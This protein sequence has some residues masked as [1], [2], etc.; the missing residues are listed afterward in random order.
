MF[1]FSGGWVIFAT[2]CIWVKFTSIHW[3]IFPISASLSLQ[4]HL[5]I[6]SMEITIYH[7]S[8]PSTTVPLEPMNDLCVTMTLNWSKWP[9]LLKIYYTKLRFFKHNLNFRAYVLLSLL[10]FLFISSL[11]IW[12]IM[13]STFTSP[14]K[15]EKS[16]KEGERQWT[17]LWVSSF[18]TKP[19][20]F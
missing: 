5:H 14:L 1:S 8:P 18:H 19:Y 9:V 10:A 13:I 6:S 15:V 7:Q 16:P 3:H 17:N 12:R 2:I 11:T 4:L 20:N